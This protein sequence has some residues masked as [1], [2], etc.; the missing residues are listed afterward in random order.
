MG[1]KTKSFYLSMSL[2]FCLLLLLLQF[3]ITPLNAIPLND[4]KEK[5]TAEY[6]GLEKG[7]FMKQWLVLG[8]IP[9]FKGE[10]D[11]G[12]SETQPLRLAT[13]SMNGNTSS[14]KMTSLT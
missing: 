13:K 6:N 1:K 8:P 12:D 11:K 5:A 14:R 4:S 9:V 7:Q 3:S 10:E 2:S